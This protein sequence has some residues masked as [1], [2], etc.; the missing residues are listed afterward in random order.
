[1]S[2]IL[3]PQR[4]AKPVD[5][6]I[7]ARAVRKWSRG[8]SRADTLSVGPARP[9]AFLFLPAM[10]EFSTRDWGKNRSQNIDTRSAIGQAQAM[11]VKKVV[12]LE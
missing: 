1:M 12:G 2:P 8:S 4:A 7:L 6:E 3:Y 5:V 10:R 9:L 11:V